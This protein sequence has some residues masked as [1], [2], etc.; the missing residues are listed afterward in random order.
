M[1]KNISILIFLIFVMTS[2]IIK[3]Q[4]I[5]YET[6]FIEKDNITKEQA[7][8]RFFHF[9]AQNPQFANTYIQLANISENILLELDPFREIELVDYWANNSVLFYGLFAVYF[10]SGE[11]RRNREY[12]ANIP[13]G[14]AG[15]TNEND[16]IEYVNSR[17][18]YVQ[19]YKDSVK[20]I[21]YALEKSKD[22]YNNCVRIFNN[23][24]E[25]F[26]NFNE[27][28]LRT[29][30]G[31]I[32][33]LKELE[34]EFNSCIEAFE[35]Y[36]KLLKAYPLKGHKKTYEVQIGQ[37][38]STVESIVGA[39]NQ[40]YK[41]KP[42]Y[43]F[44]LDGIT[45]S[46]FLKDTFEIWDYGKWVND[47]REIFNSDISSLRKEVDQIQKSFD[48]NQRFLARVDFVEPEMALRSYDELFLFRLGKYDNNSLI[49]E[50]FD[51]LNVRQDFMLMQKYALNVSTDSTTEVMSRKLR[52]YYRLALQLNHSKSSLDNF[53]TEVSTDK[54]NRFFDFFKTYYN[55]EQGL[56]VFCNEQKGFLYN[57]FDSGINNLKEYFRNNQDLKNSYKNATGKGADIPLRIIETKED[58]Q[59]YSF[60][61]RDIFYNYDNPQY[62]S[63]Y[64]KKSGKN[65]PFVARIN[66][67]FKV[68]WIKE[69]PQ[70]SY[71]SGKAEKVFAYENGVLALITD[72]KNNEDNGLEHKNKLVHCD[73]SGK[74]IFDKT[75]EDTNFPV[76]LHYDEINQ[77]SNIV[78]GKKNQRGE[79]FDE[80]SIC[81]ADSTGT[82]IWENNIL[83]KGNL[84]DIIRAE[85]KYIA[86]I[87]FREY[88]VAGVK[89][90]AGEGNK[91][92][93]VAVD[94]SL[95][96]RVLKAVPFL[97]NE[98]YYIDRIYNISSDEI[99]LLGYL[100]SPG[101]KSGKLVYI[102][103]ATDGEII[104]KNIE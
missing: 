31:F 32:D 63:G 50:L 45:N 24:N 34:F 46:D 83:A 82:I 28:L 30:A 53:C 7:F 56:I 1:Y 9:Q 37:F 95:D 23:I 16:F 92:A 70:E 79:F 66:N 72:F 44:R 12:Y 54:V 17:K 88:E 33:K 43:T 90:T 67:D 80:F 55:G 4:E 3:S 101:D 25:E 94:I 51:Y 57:N 98:S 38:K 89:K 20:L 22:H 68:E 91:W 97:F 19:S 69:F 73:K 2:N 8:S 85:E 71:S 58:A 52:Y 65:V 42:I 99:N 5:K 100:G 18:T 6:I 104:F 49:R 102:V 35:E 86:F 48:E 39:Y 40:V 15:R 78:F 84:I 47:Y 41:L 62:V 36:K 26:D 87:N 103:V 74:V 77:I 29:D 14:A 96:G 76:Y 13:V 11:L 64:A 21:F 81:Q 59:K 60:I 61:T 75:I 10:N 93:T 27:V